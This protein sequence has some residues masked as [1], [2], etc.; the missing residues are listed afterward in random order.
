MFHLDEGLKFGKSCDEI[1]PAWRMSLRD[2]LE[3]CSEETEIG[4]KI[5]LVIIEPGTY[6]SLQICDSE[7]LR[8]GV[9]DE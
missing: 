9:R 5:S 6:V 4:C 3:P 1:H 8:D 2:T 7:G